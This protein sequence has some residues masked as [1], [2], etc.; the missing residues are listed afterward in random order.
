V[1]STAIETLLALIEGLLPEIGIASSSI[2]EKIL[3]AL[4]SI[5]PIIASNATNLIAPVKNIIA[6]LQNSGPV[7]PDQLATL[8]SLDA[9]C[10]AAF[11]AAAAQAGAPPNPQG[12]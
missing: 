6:A 3:A 10:D 8:A 9:Q 7:T 11:E 4:I 2:V 1:L 5:V 12:S